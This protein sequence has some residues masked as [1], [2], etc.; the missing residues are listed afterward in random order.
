[1][2]P[3]DQE[4]FA[5]ERV[6][7]GGKAIGHS[8]D[9]KVCFFGA[10]VP[11][12]TVKAS[13]K[14]AKKHYNVMKDTEVIVASQLRQQSVC[15][16]GKTCGGCQ[17]PDIS[18]ANQAQWKEQFIADAIQRTAGIDLAP[19]AI[20]FFASEIATGYRHRLRIKGRLTQGTF[21]WGFFAAES[22]SLVAVDAC[23]IAHPSINTLLQQLAAR[24]WHGI[25]NGDF[26]WD[27]M[28][29]QAPATSSQAVPATQPILLTHLGGLNLVR[30]LKPLQ[31]SLHLAWIGTRAAALQAPF[32][33]W[34]VHAGITYFTKP[35]QFQQAHLSQNHIL[36]AKLQDILE[37]YAPRSILDLYCGS[38][39][40][41]LTWLKHAPPGSRLRGVEAA[42]PAIA[43]GRENAK[44]SQLPAEF[45]CQDA[46]AFLRQDQDRS[47]DIVIVDPP[48][49]GLGATAA[50]LANKAP[51]IV[52]VACDPMTLARDLKTLASAGYKPI[53]VL[54]FDMFPNT[55]HVETIVVLE[56]Q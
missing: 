48:R 29:C 40:L 49:Q 5:I 41:S 1:M 14:K 55:Y 46:T 44:V 20:S 47:Y 52:Y 15:R 33:V 16:F 35:G 22:H 56:Q 34:E 31:R 8:R 53:Q 12:D 38:G 39:N 11:G 37:H 28:V 3:D 21:S 7:Y 30:H 50:L 6:A 17:W 32:F 18:L 4:T 9:Q 45:I 54:G 42:A 51:I 26:E 13:I 25:A 10:G 43:A 23:Q 2:R 19:G 24:S 36:K 27:L